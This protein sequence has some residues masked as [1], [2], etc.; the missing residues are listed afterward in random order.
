MAMNGIGAGRPLD[1]KRI[2]A[3]LAIALALPACADDLVVPDYNNPSLE[4]LQENPTR[5]AVIT[6]TQGLLIGARTGIANQAGFIA[7]TGILGRESYTFDNSDPRYVNEMVHGTLDPGNGAFG[8]SGWSP[9]YANIRNANIVL[10]ALDRVTGL[11]AEELEGIRGFAKTIQALD[12]LL[13]IA[14]RDENGAVIDVDRDITEEP[15]P[16]VGKDEVLAHV[17]SLLDEAAAHLDAAGASFA[18][19]LS[20]GFAA[21]DDPAS[22]RTFN[23]ALKARVEAYRGNYDAVLDALDE[24]FLD[25]SPGADLYLGAYHAFQADAPNGLFNP[26][27]V[28]HP[29]IRDDAELQADGTT[30]DQRVLDKTEVLDEPAA[31]GGLTTNLGFT[32]YTA[33]NAPAPIIRNEELILLRAEAYIG[34]GMIPQAAADI[35]FIRVNSGGLEARTDLDATNIVDELLRQR[36]FSLLLEGHRWIDMRRF[37]R[38]GDLPIDRDGDVVPSAFPIPR[39][40]CIARGAPVPCGVGS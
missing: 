34:L 7:H 29:S 35:N 23:R 2:V 37:G 24:S 11:T 26:L 17:S 18:F 22:F 12:Y 9:R 14:L 32:I 1:R 15:G 33:A 30:L 5:T 6:A 40:E 16:I 27:I 13:V 36:R 8:G 31:S 4:E 3:A 39:A 38:L 10:H 19:S 20:S 21:F 25:A 28:A